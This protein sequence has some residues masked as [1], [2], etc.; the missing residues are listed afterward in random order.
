MTHIHLQAKPVTT[1]R[2]K[3]SDLLL[4]GRITVRGRWGWVASAHP[5]ARP[6]LPCTNHA[7]V[8]QHRPGPVVGLSGT[9]AGLPFSAIEIPMTF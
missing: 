9:G 7:P 8:Q 6:A 3:P 4:L 5:P 1:A 2:R